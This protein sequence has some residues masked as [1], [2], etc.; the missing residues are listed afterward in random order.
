M[1]ISKL[2]QEL[3]CTQ[4][5]STALEQ[6]LKVLEDVKTAF[7]D[8]LRVAALYALRYEAETASVNNVRAILRTKAH[9]DTDRARSSAVD[10]LLTY[11][12]VKQRSGDLF[13]NKSFL[14]KASKFFSSGLKGVENVFSQH[15]PLL[16]ETLVRTSRPLTSDQNLRRCDCPELNLPFLAFAIGCGH[17]ETAEAAGLPI[18]RQQRRGR[19]VSRAYCVV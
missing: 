17:Q 12:G 14:S 4:D 5:H 18:R 15:K 9:N 3:A 8:K 19:K 1:E 11:A 13:G 10:E 16:M 7:E 6:V 2:E